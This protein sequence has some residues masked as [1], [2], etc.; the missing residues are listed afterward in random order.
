[1]NMIYQNTDEDVQRS[2]EESQIKGERPIHGGFRCGSANQRPN[3]RSHGYETHY[4]V[5]KRYAPWLE[6]EMLLLIFFYLFCRRAIT[7]SKIS[8]ERNKN[9]QQFFP[10]LE[11][12]VLAFWLYICMMKEQKHIM[13]STNHIEFQDSSWS[14]VI[15]GW[16]T[17]NSTNNWV[18]KNTSY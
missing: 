12:K 4:C 15:N 3:S 18:Y 14:D 5:G 16:P 11:Y 10:S 17:N 6:Q 8:R 2:W 13:S 1:M 7:I 9:D